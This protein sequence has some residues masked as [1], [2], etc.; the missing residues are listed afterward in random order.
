MRALR[1]IALI[2]LLAPPWL[3]RPLHAEDLNAADRDA[4]R[5]VIENQLAA[6]QRDDGTA[7]FALAS[8]HIREE[9]GTIENFMEMVR[10]GYRPVYRPREVVFGDVTVTD[11]RI[12]QRV[13]LVGPDG[14][15]VTAL[16]TMEQQPD[17]TWRIAGCALA[18]TTDK[19]T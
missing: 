2:L 8:P 1:L 7:A 6:F 5:A 9:F 16:Y 14:A 11:G 3:A 13:L 19:T 4:I 18:R 12:V 17:G 10:R 15:P